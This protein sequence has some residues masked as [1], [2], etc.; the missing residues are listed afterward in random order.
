[1]KRL[2]VIP[3]LFFAMACAEVK[4]K[5]EDRS[6]GCVNGNCTNKPLPKPSACSGAQKFTDLSGT[7]KTEPVTSATTG[8]TYRAQ[9]FF[10]GNKASFTQFCE[11]KTSGEFESPMVESTYSVNSDVSALKF[12]DP[13]VVEKKSASFSC[14][15]QLTS[16]V[17]AISAQGKCLVIKPSKG[18][19]LYY[20]KQ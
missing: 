13:Q 15:A 9:F 16:E 18:D 7:F 14:K 17:F 8:I 19:A 4:E 6:G 20:V 5:I 12:D 2:L 3:F 11:K 10:S 1:M